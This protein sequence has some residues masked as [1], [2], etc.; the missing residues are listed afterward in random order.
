[1]SKMFIYAII[2]SI[3]DIICLINFLFVLGDIDGM[4]RRGSTTQQF[5][6][7]ISTLLPPSIRDQCHEYELKQVLYIES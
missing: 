6:L 4:E 5:N 1:M 3:V 2:T 7:H